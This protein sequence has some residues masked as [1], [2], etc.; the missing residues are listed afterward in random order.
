MLKIF[1]VLKVSEDDL[2][3]FRI[4]QH[5]IESRDRY[6]HIE[7]PYRYRFPTDTPMFNVSLLMI[8]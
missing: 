8:M 6:K 2:P 1:K 4:Y 7:T 3:M 5:P